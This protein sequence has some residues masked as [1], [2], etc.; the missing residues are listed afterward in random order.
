MEDAEE[1]RPRIGHGEDR[2]ERGEEDDG[3]PD[4]ELAPAE[5]P[6]RGPRTRLHALEHGWNDVGSLG[7]VEVASDGE[8]RLLELAHASTS[9]RS[10]SRA[11]AVRDLTVPRRRPST[12]AVSSSVSSRK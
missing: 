5:R 6:R 11:L 1:R 8:E 10:R 9:P 2:G 7:Q 12:S 3:H 4:R